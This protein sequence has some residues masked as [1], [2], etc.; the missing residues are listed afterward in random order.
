[1]APKR[2]VSVRV[3]KYIDGQ[4]VDFGVPVRFRPVRQE[5]ETG[6]RRTDQ[7]RKLVTTIAPV[8][9]Y[10]SGVSVQLPAGKYDVE[11]VLPSGEQLSEEIDVQ[12]NDDEN[13]ATPL[14]VVLRGEQSP[15]EWRS[16]SSFAGS[17]LASSR[18]VAL[19]TTKSAL[20][21]ENNFH[22]T[23]G[24]IVQSDG[25]PGF[26]PSS[27]DA[28]FSFL[29]ARHDRG[30][31]HSLDIR[32]SE[33]LVGLRA[34]VYPGGG[35][36]VQ[37]QF[38]QDGGLKWYAPDT[39]IIGRHRAYAAITARAVTR[40]VALPWP[41][42]TE[43]Q[44]LQP[45]PFELLAYEVQ[46]QFHCDPVLRDERWA[47]LVAY[48]NRGRVDL[49]ASI[50]DSA[51]GAL[52]EK[53]EN[54]LAAAIG[55]YVLLS[56]QHASEG[57]TWPDWLQN[58]ANR[59]PHIPDGPILRAHYLLSQRSDRS[60]E[61]AHRLLCDSV[62]RGIPF[63]T[64][65]VVWLIQ[66]L[67]R[68]TVRYPNSV[69]LLEKV[70]GVARSMDLSQAFTSFSIARPTTREEEETSPLYRSPTAAEEDFLSGGQGSERLQESTETPIPQ[71]QYI[72]L[73]ES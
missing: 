30:S 1:M 55:G 53:F 32:L 23:T 48:F 68:T 36:A 59:F 9:M 43:V 10:G 2:S 12:E 13:A 54:P 5:T 19:E 50:L 29:S 42:S 37:I 73:T 65:G 56:T 63:F 51:L 47:G 6:A 34:H 7:S 11:A 69:A 24:S 70:R 33:D 72:K 31:D 21:F 66:G 44:E 17:P 60:F 25:V 8:S 4:H 49:A 18:Q 39:T 64:T 15:N 35:T 46:G 22:V 41:W 57:A 67:Q 40:V 58:L 16:W 26:D 14:N 61:E 27:W 20:P 45:S 38:V 62:G 52:M 71:L 28:W 3:D